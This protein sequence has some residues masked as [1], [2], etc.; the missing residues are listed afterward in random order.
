MSRQDY[1]TVIRG[2][3]LPLHHLGDV[4]IMVGMVAKKK[5]SI[6]R[7]WVWERIEDYL[8]RHRMSLAA[9]GRQLDADRGA[10][11]HWRKN[12]SIPD[13]QVPAVA[14]LLGVSSE[15]VSSGKEPARGGAEAILRAATWA[16]GYDPDRLIAIG[17]HL[18][19][20]SPEFMA[21]EPKQRGKVLRA[22]Y[23][24]D[25]DTIT[26]EAFDEFLKSIQ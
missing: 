21:M 10:V 25:A 6:P 7:P 20:I 8:R 5:T 14:S 19:G 13:Y 18:D 17:R 15:W 26:K 16:I 4:T 1:L 11:N 23:H 12:K 3:F 9:F 2:V 24:A 22:I